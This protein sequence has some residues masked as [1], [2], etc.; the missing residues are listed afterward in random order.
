M[1]TRPPSRRWGAVKARVRRGYLAEGNPLGNERGDTLIEI[2][3]SLTVLSLVGV[4]MLTAFSTSI[5]ASAEHRSLASIDTVMRSAAETVTS[6]LQQRPSPLYVSCA[7]PG[8]YNNALTW[9]LPTGYSASITSVAYWNGKNFISTCV[10]A[11]TTPQLLT[12]LVTNGIYSDSMS[13]TIDDRGAISTVGTQLAVPTAVTLAPSTTTSGALT[14]TFSGSSNAPGGQTYSAI[15]CTDSAMTANCVT[16]SPF[17]SGLQITGLV[18]GQAY[19]ATITANPSSGWLGAT[20]ATVGPIA[21]TTQLNVPLITGVTG[22]STTLTVTFTTSAGAPGGQSYSATSCTN[23]AMTTGCATVANFASG[24]QLTGLVSGTTYYL[25]VTANA[26]SGYLAGVSTV[27]NASTTTQLGAPTGVTLGYGTIVGS[28]TVA[29]TASANAPGGQTYSAQLCTNAAMTTGCVAVASLTS[30]AQ[31]TGLVAG[32]LYYATVTAN[33]SSGYVAATSTVSVGAK[34]TTQLL[35]PTGVVVVGGSTG[36]SLAL[37]FTASANAAAGQT[38]TATACTN[39]GMSSGCITTSGVASGSS[40]VG[41]TQGATWYVTVTADASPGYLAATST[42]ASGVTS[43][44]L[45][46]PTGVG[47]AAGSSTASGSLIVT[48]TASVGAPGGQTY[49]AQLCTNAAMTTGCVAVASITS[50]AQVT[51]LVAGTLY[52]STV[53]ANASSGYAAASSAVAGP[54]TATKQLLAPTAVTG[55]AGSTGGNLTV[56][57]TGSSNGPGGQLYSATACTNAGMSTG[58]VTNGSITSGAQITGLTPSGAY[59]VT[60]TALASTGYVMATSTAV[61]P[62]TASSATQLAAP[63]GVTLGFGT[64]AG[65]LTVNF[66]ASS[67]APGG[68][69]YTVVFCTNAA[70][71]TG[72][73]SPVAVVSGAQISG[74]AAGTTYFATVTATAS[75]SYLAATSTA[76]AGVKATIQ[77]LTPTSVTPTAGTSTTSGSLTITFTVSSNAAAGQTYTAIACTNSGMTTGCVTSASFTSGAQVTGL[78]AGTSYYVTVTANVSAGYLAVTSAYV[79]PTVAVEQLLSPTS[80]TEGYGSVSGS[81]TVSFTASTN[82]PGGQLYSAQL[83]TNVSMTTGCVTAATIV[84][85]GQVTGLS[86]GTA[87]FATVTA[88]ASTGYLSATSTVST[89]LKATSVIT[90]PSSVVVTP[91]AGHKFSVTFT[92]TGGVTPASFTLTYCTNAAMTT[93]CATIPNFTSGTSTGN[94]SAGTYWVTITAVAPSGYLNNTSAVVGPTTV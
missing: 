51:G 37:S 41:M 3:M 13:V 45:A 36:G 92:E 77:L 40:L 90:A 10:P 8:D 19:Y 83:C 21:A 68:Q 63:T 67:N 82:A 6:Q 22:G 44:Q 84:S 75:T 43:T 70:M 18:A 88:S 35:A 87:Y 49:S 11:S 16:R 86:A 73:T 9:S 4:T 60:V 46:A 65:S 79:G 28:L 85:G 15:A 26:S 34:A 17:A 33:A 71:T 91:G 81:L 72:C 48:F 54:T 29:F 25:T 5:S 31:V 42:V 57:F 94:I 74:L 47:L 76:S 24:S 61:G 2:L 69:L 1:T 66:T 52:Y 38:Y 59:Y 39:V 58:C 78:S 27:T 7:L 30:G 23:A 50:G 55:A 20:S 93:G 80:V 53:T 64:L 32:T 56:T 89:N 14:A 62:F 12:L